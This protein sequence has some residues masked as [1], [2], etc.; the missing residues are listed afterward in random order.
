MGCFILSFVVLGLVFT[1]KCIQALNFTIE[2]WNR[3]EI[4]LNAAVNYSTPYIDVDDLIGTF[5]SPTGISMT[6]PGF[7]DG[8]QTW[9]IR[10]APTLVGIW[11][12]KT[13]ARDVGLTNQTGFI[14]CTPYT[15]TLPIYQ[16]GFITPS[17]NNRYLIYADGT[18]FYWL[19]DTHWTGFSIAERFNESNDARFSS[20]FKGMIDRRVEQGYTVWK[21]ETFAKNRGYNGSDFNFNEGGRVWNNDNYFVDLNPRFWQNIDQRMDYLA[22]KG[23]V[24]SI[25]QGIGSSMKNISVEPDHK[26]LALYILARYGAYPTVWMTAQE[27]DDVR[28]GTCGQCWADIAAYIYDLDPYKRANSLHNAHTNPIVYHDQVWYGFVTL[29]EGHNNVKLVDYWLTQ[30][31]AIPP[32]PILEDEANY[33]DIIPKYGGG[34]PTH[35]WKTRQSG[36]QAQVAGAFGFTYGAQGIWWGCYTA[37][38]RNPNCGN[39][40]DAR[41]W[42]TAIDFPVGEQMSFMAQFWTSFNWWTLA[43][44]ENAIIWSSAPNNTQR[45]YQKTDGNN[46]TLVIAYLPIYWNGNVYNGTVRNLSPMGIYT[47]QWFNPRNGTYIIIAEGWRPTKDGSW[48]IPTQPTAIDDWALKIER[49]NGSNVSPNFAFGMNTDS[50]SNCWNTNQTSNKVV[51]DDLNT[52]WQPNDSEGFNNSWLSVNFRTQ[53]TF[54]EVRI[55]EYDQRT[56]SYRIEYWNGTSWFIAYIGSTISDQRIRFP[57][58]TGSQMRVVFTSGIGPAPII[59]ELEV[60]D[61]TLTVI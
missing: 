7:W 36:W 15:G 55:I 47:S 9:K 42:Y 59:Y 12:Y 56:T 17:A 34:I 13:N 10:F 28:F 50:S 11:T 22:S 32:R 16:H 5:I 33:E 3:V 39:G 43:P 41:A 8:G 27:F 48:N 30:Y 58:V 60:N 35:K 44:D 23:M 24:I 46:R 51:D 21:V 57:A 14:I 20:M 53:T 18:P 19:G 52:S 1:S 40:S 37:Q 38:D 54:N 4:P 6:M 31:N 29:Q 61:S 2:C 26:R 45:P 25:A 49:I